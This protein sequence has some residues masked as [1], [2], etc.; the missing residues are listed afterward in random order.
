V[1]DWFLKEA[2][3]DL[4]HGSYNGRAEQIICDIC[5][6]NIVFSALEKREGF[7]VIRSHIELRFIYGSKPGMIS[8]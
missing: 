3:A 7:H 2:G 5:S 6:P 8:D 1:K 4:I